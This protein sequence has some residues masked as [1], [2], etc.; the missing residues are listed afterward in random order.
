VLA[1]PENKTTKV[2]THRRALPD[3]LFLSVERKEDDEQVGLLFECQSRSEGLAS[4]STLLVISG[5]TT[6]SK[7]SK[8][9]F[10]KS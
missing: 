4:L 9:L 2:Y 1:S 3:N 5:G 6:D 8:Y 7:H 10:D